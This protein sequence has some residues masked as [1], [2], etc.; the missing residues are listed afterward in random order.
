M[1]CFLVSEI[2]FLKSLPIIPDLLIEAIQNLDK[3]HNT[4]KV[5]I[6]R[7]L[8][9]FVQGEVNFAKIF[10]KVGTH[11]SQALS[12]INSQNMESRLRI[13]YMEVA[14]S[15]VNHNSGVHWLLES[16]SWRE[17]LMLCY[18][19]RTIFVVRQTYKFTTLFL[20]K[21]SDINDVKNIKIVLSFLLK[22]MLDT[23]WIK[24]ESMTS[25]EEDTI[26]KTVEPM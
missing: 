22:P 14:I 16:G 19:K 2:V 18:D 15:L 20:W 24:V 1:I 9:V 4:V 8:G 11:V 23:D 7:L 3:Y 5:F 25:E 21:L 17:I 13:A 6:V 10:A 26:C 12:N